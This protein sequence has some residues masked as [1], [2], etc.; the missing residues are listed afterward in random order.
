MKTVVTGAR[1]FVGKK[2]VRE[3]VAKG[4]QAVG[5]DLSPAPPGPSPEGLTHIQA[6]TAREGAWQQ[7]AA[8]A[9]AVVNLAGV[10]IFKR[11]NSAYKN[12]MLNSRV[13]TTRRVTEALSSGAVLA[14]ASAAGYYGD[15]GEK[16]ITEKN[17]PG[18]DFLARVCVEWEGEALL[19][20]RKDARVALMRFGVVLDRDGGALKEMLLPFRLGLGGPLGSGRQWFSW[21]HARDLVRAV[22]FVLEN[23]QASGAFNFTSP[24]P[25]R[26]KEFASALGAA[27]GRPAVIPLPGPVL[28]LAMGEMAGAVLGGQKVLP[29][30]LLKAGFVHEFPDM[31][32]ALASIAGKRGNAG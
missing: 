16:E 19:A 27:L 13:L 5:I 15:T 23:P 30:R 29:A 22:L 4:H 9:D 32:R 10:S 11:W 14:S 3:L 8:D 17:G 6:D 28:R 25:L 12:Y 7:E 21:I 1:G 24:E 2:L 18:A 20:A 31:G 26:N